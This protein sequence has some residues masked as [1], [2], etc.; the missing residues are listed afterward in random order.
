MPN[1]VY[2]FRTC[3]ATHR[4]LYKQYD[5]TVQ[6]DARGYFSANIRPNVNA[7]PGMRYDVSLRAQSG[8][9]TAESRITL[10]QR[11]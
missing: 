7:V 10:H 8:S 5:E 1:V 4:T 2:A 6:A 3:A 11:G 9:Q